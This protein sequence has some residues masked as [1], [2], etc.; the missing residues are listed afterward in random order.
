ME[1]AGAIKLAVHGDASGH[2]IFC[3]L[4]DASGERHDLPICK[5]IDWKGWKVLHREHGEKRKENKR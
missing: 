2:R 5:R 1:S 4:A 3:V